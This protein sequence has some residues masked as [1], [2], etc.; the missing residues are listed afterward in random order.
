MNMKLKMKIILLALLGLIFF[1]GLWPSSAQRGQGV[2]IKADNG[3]EIDLYDE[4]YALVIGVSKYTNGWRALPGVSRDV[5]AVNAVLTKQGFTVKVITDPTFTQM[6]QAIR[7]FISEYGLKQRNRLLIY[8]AGHGYTELRSDGRDLGYIIPADAP[9]PAQNPQLFSRRAMSMDDM[10]AHARRIN[11]KHALFIFD[12]CFSG[13]IFEARG[14]LYVPPEIASKTAAPVRQFITSGT[15][16]QTVPDTSIFRLYFVRAFEQ[17]EGDLNHDDFITGEELGIYLSGKV[18]RDSREAQTPRYGKINDARLN[19]GDMV[20]ALPAAT[21]VVK[22]PNTS[23]AF[24]LAFWNSISTSLNVQDFDAYLEQYPNGRF[25]SLARNK[26]AQLLAELRRPDSVRPLTGSLAFTPTPFTTAKLMNGSVTR[27][28]AV[29]DSYAEDLGNGIKLEMT[30]VPAGKFLM[31]SPVNEAER[32]E[33]EGP[34]REVSVSS[35][36]MGRFEVT[37]QQWR[38]VAG[39]PK[40]GTELIASPSESKGDRLPVE[41]ISWI[42]AK[43]FIARLNKKLGLTKGNEYRLPSEAE[44]EYAAR[45]GTTTPFAFGSGLSMDV[46]NFDGRVKGDKKDGVKVVY[47]DKPVEVGSVGIANAF[48]LFDLHGNLWE[49]CEDD[50]HPTFDDAPQ[51]GQPWITDFSSRDSRRLIRGGSFGSK[52]GD[53]RAARRIKNTPDFRGKDLGFRLARNYR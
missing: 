34:Q 30:R 11:A 35:F 43:E 50:W 3:A 27:S 25:A 47:R 53:C 51:T 10:E 24:E 32:K 48:G 49:W 29:C 26:K 41:K 36:L 7:D 28:Q 39:W 31:G 23:E 52:S 14:T 46:V 22:P 20:F 12:S 15:K 38:L 33:D 5:T 2:R 6:D 16:N 18:S 45:S 17:R 19:I 21:V 13:S 4:S 8:F 40:V 1:A 9:L 42:E 44:W 37:Q